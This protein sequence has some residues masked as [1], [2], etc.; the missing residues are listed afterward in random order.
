MADPRLMS[1][2]LEG[3][4]RRDDFR[5]A[6]DRVQAACG[7]LTRLAEPGEALVPESCALSDG[8]TLYALRPGINSIGRLADNQICLDDAHVSRRH[9]A[10]VLHH[11]GQLEVHDV[12]SK[13][14]TVV[15][16]R[17]IA[18]PTRLH[19]G[20]AI[21]LCRLRLTV[22]ARPAEQAA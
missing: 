16:G 13:N 5:A 11:D 6:R 19:L 2:H 7:E 14:G 21:T 8:A 12:A 18:G 22:V 1:L 15:N 17:K 4:P 20:D 3:L 10:V 9:C